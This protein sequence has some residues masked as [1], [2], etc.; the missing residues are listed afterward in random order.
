M[1][2]ESL[3]IP[4]VKFNFHKQLVLSDKIKLS[5]FFFGDTLTFGRL[6]VSLAIIKTMCTVLFNKITNGSV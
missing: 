5:Y 3:D 6:F 4:E 1:F 2:L